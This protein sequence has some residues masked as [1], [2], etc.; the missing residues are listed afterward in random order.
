MANNTVMEIASGVASG[1]ASSAQEMARNLCAPPTLDLGDEPTA[2]RLKGMWTYRDGVNVKEVEAFFKE[3]ANQQATQSHISLLEV[4]VNLLTNQAMAA[5]TE[6]EQK[7]VAAEIAIERVKH[8]KAEQLLQSTIAQLR[9]ELH[10]VT[11]ERDAQQPTI[12]RLTESNENKDAA[13]AQLTA[14]V[15]KQ[16]K[17]LEDIKATLTG[18]L[19]K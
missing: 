9:L 14:V 7:Q 11:A 15:S 18:C 1:V 2:K 8:F 5:R 10:N 16:S 19:S 13:I 17:E 6:E 4:Q 3:H 12:T